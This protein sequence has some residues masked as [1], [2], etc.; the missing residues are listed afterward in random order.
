MQVIFDWL[1]ANQGVV[2]AGAAVITFLGIIATVVGII[3][4][5]KT[6]KKDDKTQI[7]GISFQNVNSYGNGRDGV[8]VSM[9]NTIEASMLSTHQRLVVEKIRKEW[10]EKNNRS[11]VN[12]SVYDTPWRKHELEWVNARLK[13]QGKTYRVE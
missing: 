5:I 13:E 4:K 6:S 8:H 12:V 3:I 10:S 1:N 9:G 2:R 7:A 11:S